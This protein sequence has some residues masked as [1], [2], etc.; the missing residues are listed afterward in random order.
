MAYRIAAPLMESLEALARRVRTA[1]I[2]DAMGRLHRHRCH[3]LDFVSPT[4]G[5]QLFGP[6]VTISY[7]PACRVAR[8]PDDYN[9]KKLF[10]QAIEGGAEGRVL[11]L[12]GNG[13]TEVS[14]GGATKLSRAQNHRLAGVLA[15][16]RLRDFSELEHYDLAI[17]CRGETTRWGG[18]S[19]TPY[20]ANRAVVLG[21]VAVCPGDYVFADA[22]GAAVIPAGDVRTVLATAN[23][24]VASDAESVAQIRVE[25]PY[26]P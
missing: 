18:D 5:R 6:A 25:N 17:Y 2:L 13:Y 9:F 26:T 24:V 8:P 16:G 14:L 11:V 1:D 20:E 4:P 15:D 21:G 19:V 10:Y 12:A 7:F 22:S 3:L 23:Q